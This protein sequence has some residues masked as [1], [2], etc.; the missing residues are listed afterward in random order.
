[1]NQ[2]L[3][4]YNSSEYTGT[5]YLVVR[6]STASGAIPLPNATV[7]IRGNEP[8]FSAVI[9]RLYSGQDGLTQKIALLTPPRS[10]TDSPTETKKPYATYNVEVYLDGYHPISAQGIPLFDGITS[11]QPADMIPIPKNG[12]LTPNGDT[13]YTESEPPSL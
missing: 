10:L 2:D 1:M 4:Q 11:I 9:A 7:L 8:D 5:G 6:V 13:Q 12:M 3:P